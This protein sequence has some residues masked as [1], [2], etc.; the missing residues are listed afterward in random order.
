M[1]T[2]VHAAAS[3]TTVN[4]VD[5]PST[6][7]TLRPP[8]RRPVTLITRRQAKGSNH[9]RQRDTQLTSLRQR[10]VR[11][12]SMR[13]IDHQTLPGR[14]LM[15][16]VELIHR[17]NSLTKQSKLMFFQ[18]V[19]AQ[20]ISPQRGTIRASTT[21]RCR[22]LLRFGGH[23]MLRFVPGIGF[24]S[25]GPLGGLSIAGLTRLFSL[26]KPPKIMSTCA[27]PADL[28]LPGSGRAIP[29]QHC[30]ASIR[31]PREWRCG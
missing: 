29:A 24:S 18:F 16:S 4:R 27:C 6:R 31:L 20:H 26:K 19:L 8:S 5:T 30:R 1:P 17:T 22:R 13:P 25:G 21:R 10:R 12:A 7:T 28:V 15:Q 3:G 2:Q 23:Q 11:L 14:D 9:A